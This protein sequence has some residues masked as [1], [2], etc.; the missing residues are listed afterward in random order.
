[1][2]PQGTP[3]TDQARTCG[4]IERWKG[5]RA[6][7]SEIGPESGD[8][9]HVGSGLEEKQLWRQTEAKKKE[10]VYLEFVWTW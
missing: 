5:E 8:A 4:W 10:D 1:M 6:G 2:R 9:R 7:E 3:G